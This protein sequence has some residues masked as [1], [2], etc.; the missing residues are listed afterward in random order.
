MATRLVTTHDILHGHVSL[1]IECLDGIY[2]NGY[3]PSLQVGGQIANCLAARGLPIPY[4]A[5]LN[6]IGKRFREAVRRFAESNC[7][8]VV[9]FK[10]GGR[11]IDVI[12][13][14]LGV[15][16]ARD[17]PPGQPVIPPAPEPAPNAATS[18]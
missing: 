10:K 17:V 1:D 15:R 16:S 8:P 7:I 13:R 18:K 11:K 4:P 5:V 12:R 2:L 9:R 3:V 6:R 14:H